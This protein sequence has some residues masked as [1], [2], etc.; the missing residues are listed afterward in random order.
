VSR[1]VAE[2]YGVTYFDFHCGMLLVWCVEHDG[3]LDYCVNCVNIIVKLFLFI[4]TCY[5]E[6]ETCLF[7][8]LDYPAIFHTFLGDFSSER[9]VWHFIYSIASSG[10]FAVFVTYFCNY[11]LYSDLHGIKLRHCDALRSCSDSTV[12]FWLCATDGTRSQSLTSEL[13]CYSV[14]SAAG[15]IGAKPSQQS[16]NR[17]KWLHLQSY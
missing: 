14:Q 9:E 1:L 13:S 5:Q 8:P 11:M 7:E 12:A 4:L 2:G 10:K 17:L 15:W 16:C 3:I 6:R